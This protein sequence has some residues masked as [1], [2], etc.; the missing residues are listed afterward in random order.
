MLICRTR[1]LLSLLP[2]AAILHSST[3]QTHSSRTVTGTHTIPG[4]ISVDKLTIQLP[5]RTWILEAVASKTCLRS[6]KMTV[7]GLATLRVSI[8][9]H[10]IEGHGAVRVQRRDLNNL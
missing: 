2:C 1:F 4:L 7:S 9:P 10:K 3:A 5:R 8:L 6:V